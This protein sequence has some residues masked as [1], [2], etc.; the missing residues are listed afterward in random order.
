MSHWQKYHARWS[1]IHP[2]LRPNE[3]VIERLQAIVEP[4][5]RAVLLLGVTPELA[6]A[7]GH[8]TAVDK[9]PAMIRNVWP[10][11]TPTKRATEGDW[12]D[13]ASEQRRF[14]AVVGD[15]SLNNV[16]WPDEISKLLHISMDLLEP[17]GVFACRLFERPAAAISIAQ[18][19]NT[20]TAKAVTNFHAFKW[21]IAM[22]LA[23]RRGANVP[24][25]DILQSFNSLCPDREQLSGVTG[26]SHQS[27]DT[28]DVYAG[29]NIVYSFP[30]RA[31]FEQTVPG[32]ALDVTFHNCGNYDLAEC[33]PILSFRKPG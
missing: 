23:A 29:S 31:E 5:A 3:E 20:V 1:Q 30:D 9:N 24:V 33:C 8:V 16:A 4:S 7:F 11:D 6:D 12:L 2:P 27:I 19:Q 28:I 26:W 21:Q 10:G 32:S 22:H 18:L 15:G 13:L 17:G 25:I 14:A